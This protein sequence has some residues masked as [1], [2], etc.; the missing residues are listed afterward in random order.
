[1]TQAEI[2]AASPRSISPAITLSTPY[3]DLHL[4]E[5]CQIE[6]IRYTSCFWQGFLLL[7]LTFWEVQILQ[8]IEEIKVCGW[9][10]IGLS[11]ERCLWTVIKNISLTDPSIKFLTLGQV[12]RD[13]Y[14][15]TY[16]EE[17]IW[18]LTLK[19]SF[20]QTRRAPVSK[21]DDLYCGIINSPHNIPAT[22]L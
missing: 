17:R 16:F 18:G 3:L 8:C 15:V 21:T 13:S 20:V 6:A 10:E 9:Q 5:T 22:L 1:M 2:E 7:D 14:S 11:V 4:R 12:T 19:R